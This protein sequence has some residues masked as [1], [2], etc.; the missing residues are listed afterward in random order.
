MI[1]RVHPPALPYLR[2]AL[3]LAGPAPAGRRLPRTPGC[4][5]CGT[6][7]RCCAAPIVFVIEVGTR[8]VHVLRRKFRFARGSPV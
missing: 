3:R 4:S 6:R 5:C 8:H 1:I 2:P 7:S